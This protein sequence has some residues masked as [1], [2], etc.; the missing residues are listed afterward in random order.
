MENPTS[1]TK[2]F[3]GGWR[4]KVTGIIYLNAYAQTERKKNERRVQTEFTMDKFTNMERNIGVQTNFFPD[5]RDRLVKSTLKDPSF[6]RD[7]DERVLESVV[8]I[9]R[10]YRAHH[11]QETA[12]GASVRPKN[13]DRQRQIQPEPPNPYRSR[14]FVI[15]NRTPPT[16][17]T[18]FE[19]LY[20][21]L[22]RWRV[23][24]TETARSQLFEP[25]RLA[26][27]SLIL[28]KE[29]EL[30]R[31][32]DAMKTTVKFKKKEKS[33]RKFLDELSKLVPWKN[34][35]GEMIYVET[36][37]VQR[38]RYFRDIFEQLSDDDR[39]VKDRLEVLRKLRRDT[40]PHTCK[41]SDEVIRL[42]DQEI[43]LLIRNVDR[44]KLNW[45]R[46]RL[47]MAFLKL[48][49]EALRNECE[50]ADLVGCVSKIVCRSCGRLLP[51]DKFPCDKEQRSLSCNYCLY[52]ETRNEPRI[53]YEAYERLLRD[54]RRREAK[55]QCY[56]S[57]AFVIDAKIVYH[58]VNDIWHGKS[59]ISENDCLE[60][61]RLTRFRNDQ[62]WS[63]W[64]CLL[65][66]AEEASLHRKIKDPDNF[67]GAMILQKFYTKNL[68][69]KARF[70]SILEFNSG[71]EQSESN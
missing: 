50:D 18:D 48:A 5:V 52:V 65:L 34:S 24:E 35:R 12:N 45:L 63:P 13:T 3:L 43:D 11:R 56:I 30:L 61:L 25:S 39:S 40:E 62:E 47:K 23:R 32:I 1:E 2:P 19:L 6:K 20:N 29:V 60:E 67:Y 8:K 68:L 51:I 26:L 49:R 4:S 36:E 69:A 21:L 58:L 70:K 27:C 9:Q 15:L 54:L 37:R 17:R 41:I 57:L 55:L 31:A 28:S 16:T 14:D 33:Y 64:N 22:D 38:A 53:V 10:F 42:L 59:A 66:N 7:T 46:N 71:H 44:S